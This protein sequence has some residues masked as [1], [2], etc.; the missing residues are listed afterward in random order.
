MEEKT[1]SDIVCQESSSSEEKVETTTTAGPPEQPDQAPAPDK[2]KHEETTDIETLV[3]DKSAESI[4]TPEL[5]PVTSLSLSE[6]T[7]PVH[8]SVDEIKKK[9]KDCKLDEESEVAADQLE[10]A[11]TQDSDLRVVPIDNRCTKPPSS[12]KG[13]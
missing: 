4:A 5:L 13:N 7:S 8:H 9:T 11:G 10:S 12:S 1:T 3:D 2:H 6:S